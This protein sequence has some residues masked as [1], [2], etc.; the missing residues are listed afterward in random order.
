MKITDN[1]M[2]YNEFDILEIKLNIMGDYVD[3]FNIVET[4]R[5]HSGLPKDFNLEK[6]WDRYTKWHH[7][8]NYIKVSGFESQ[9]NAWDNERAN[10]DLVALGWED[11]TDEDVIIISDCDE[12]TRPQALQ[13]IRVTDYDYYALKMP[14]F[15]FKFNYMLTNDIDGFT[16]WPIAYRG[17]KSKGLKPSQMRRGWDETN[18][19]DRSHFKKGAIVNHA[20]WHFSWYGEKEDIER[21]IRSYAHTE[22]NNDKVLGSLDVDDCI[23]RGDDHL[24]RNMVKWKKI[25][26]DEYFPKY[27]RDNKEK[28]S[29]YILDGEQPISDFIPQTIMSIEDM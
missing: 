3:R 4:D 22:F 16:V 6:Q 14:I 17:V 1:F 10:R 20:G 18:N 21:K 19:R 13:Y 9:P 11:L 8:I 23:A 2:F 12:I 5:T 28:Y 7:K 25:N 29:K 24:K 26:F 27:L 15:Y